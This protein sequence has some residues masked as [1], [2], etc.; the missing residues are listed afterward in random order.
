MCNRATG[1]F[2]LKEWG[3]R[4][5]FYSVTIPVL[6]LLDGMQGVLRDKNDDGDW[7]LE[8]I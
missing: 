5:F 8:L 3:K 1:L 6:V 7:R 2:T 4:H